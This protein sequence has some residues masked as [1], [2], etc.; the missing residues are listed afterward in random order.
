MVQVVAMG[1]VRDEGLFPYF[2]LANRALKVVQVVIGIRGH[3][4]LQE[5]STHTR[6]CPDV[7]HWVRIV[8]CVFEQV[9]VELWVF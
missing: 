3:W 7:D 2:V 5:L 4:S 8:W 9:V 6:N 1:Q